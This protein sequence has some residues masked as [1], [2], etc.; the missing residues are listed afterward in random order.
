M[1]LAIVAV[2]ALILGGYLGIG[3]GAIR[4]HHAPVMTYRAP[5]AARHQGAAAT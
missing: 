1:R 3:L 4:H 2:F 5:R